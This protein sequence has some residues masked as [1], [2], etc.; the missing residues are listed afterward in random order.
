MKYLILES[1]LYE[2]SFA[3]EK[4]VTSREKLNKFLISKD[5][6]WFAF[7]VGSYLRTSCIS[8]PIVTIFY[9]ENYFVQFDI[10]FVFTA[11][12]IVNMQLLI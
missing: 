10:Y 6:V 5:I 7:L 1:N 3:E 9:I 12:M 11:A 8:F 2:P 4:T